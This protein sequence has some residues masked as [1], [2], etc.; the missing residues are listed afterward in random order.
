[1]E[2]WT[3]EFGLDTV[4]WAYSDAVEVNSVSGWDYAC[5]VRVGRP[6]A[7]GFYGQTGSAGAQSANESYGAAK[8][9]FHGV[10]APNSRYR[11][12]VTPLSIRKVKPVTADV[13]ADGREEPKSRAGK[14]KG[15]CCTE[16][17]P[18]KRLK[19]VFNGAAQV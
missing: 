13:E 8:V 6:S 12:S 14:R 5:G 17:R 16:G 3:V 2:H 10:L 9:R 18:A 15:L 19:R 7:V 1:M 4:L 11:E